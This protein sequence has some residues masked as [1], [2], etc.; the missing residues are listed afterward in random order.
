M[1]WNQINVRMKK[2]H[3]DFISKVL[4]CEPIVINSEKLAPHLRHRLYWTN[5]PNLEQ[6]IDLGLELND[7]LQVIHSY[8]EISY[9]S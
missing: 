3:Q 8:N 7:F 5:I 6:P 9:F 1:K 2:E 4:G